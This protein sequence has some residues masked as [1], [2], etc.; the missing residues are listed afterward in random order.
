MKQEPITCHP[1]FSQLLN[2]SNLGKRLWN[3]PDF[4]V[5]I[6]IY[7]EL[8]RKSSLNPTQWILS[9]SSTYYINSVCIRNLKK[10]WWMVTCWKSLRFKCA[11]ILQ[12]LYSW[13]LGLLIVALINCK[14]CQKYKI[15][16][17]E[18]TLN[19]TL[20]NT[21]FLENYL[22]SFKFFTAEWQNTQLFLA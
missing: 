13:K 7:E 18:N 8:T 19:W 16:K 20:S 3:F 9:S 6:I 2:E 22:Q 14:P 12:L 1:P 21:T 15:T 17:P 5:H 11:W 4:S 10:G